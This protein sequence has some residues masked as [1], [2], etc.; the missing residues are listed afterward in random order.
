MGVVLAQTND[1]PGARSRKTDTY[2]SISGMY[3]PGGM[4]PGTQPCSPMLKCTTS[5]R[6]WS[7]TTRK[8]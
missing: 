4:R 8:S 3:C 6:C 7:R 5:Y 1:P 2:S